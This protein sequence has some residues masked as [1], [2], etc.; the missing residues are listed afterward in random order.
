MGWPRGLFPLVH[1]VREGFA[2][3]AAI[4]LRKQSCSIHSEQ[5]SFPPPFQF[6]SILLG[7]G[8]LCKPVWGDQT[9]P[10][11]MQLFSLMLSRAVPKIHN[12]SPKEHL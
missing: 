9:Q 11:G 3:G 10:L 7:L 5:A 1:G 2:L 8:R 12:P 4:C 6:A